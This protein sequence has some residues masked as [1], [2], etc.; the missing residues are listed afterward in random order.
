MELEHTSEYETADKAQSEI[1]Y[2]NHNAN[3]NVAT[4]E[5]E[6]T[7]Y[8]QVGNICHTLESNEEREQTTHGTY[9]NPCTEVHYNVATIM[10]KEC[11]AYGTTQDHVVMS[12]N[13]AYGYVKVNWLSVWYGNHTHYWQTCSVD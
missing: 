7:D 6:N 13:P 8:D 4:P 3:F 11:V 9:V 2:S 12:T 1:T 10:T 5:Y